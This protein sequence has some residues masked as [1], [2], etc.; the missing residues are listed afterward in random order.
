[1]LWVAV[2]G[3]VAAVGLWAYFALD[4]RARWRTYLDALRAEPGIVIVSTGREGGR[5]AVHGLR[6]PLA[7]DPASLVEASGLSADD[8]TGHWQMYQ[9]LDAP[10]VAARA[11]QLLRAP[12]SV[13]LA[14]DAGVLTAGGRAPVEWILGT[15]ELAPLVPGV[16]RF[17]TGE[18]VEAHVRRIDQDLTAGPLLFVR[19]STAFDAGGGRLLDAHLLRIRELQAVAELSDRHFVVEAV[20]H[21]DGDGTPE[22]N[23]SL[24]VRRA[25]LV[26]AAIASLGTPRIQVLARGVGSSQPA[27]PGLSEADKRANRRVTL[28]LAPPR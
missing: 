25:D 20:G 3:L 27:R 4:A 19:G 8:V 2:A 26:R 9:A 28:R 16:Q 12:D 11:R 10:I 23:D 22:T 5:F 21:A 24:S 15:R 7:R 14:F 18:L 6:D 13:R 17:D 1:M